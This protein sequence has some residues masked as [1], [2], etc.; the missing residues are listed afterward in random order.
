MTVRRRCNRFPGQTRGGQR[1]RRRS[2]TTNGL[3]V[4]VAL[5]TYTRLFILRL[6]I[7]LP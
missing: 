2:A 1:L 7:L 4:A 6:F 5:R 3:L